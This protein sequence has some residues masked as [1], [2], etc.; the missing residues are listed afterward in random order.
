M[1]GTM[2]RRDVGVDE[3]DIRVVVVEAGTEG[4]VVV[5]AE[6]ISTRID[7]GVRRRLMRYL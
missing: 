3:M 5:V 1:I 6:V 2:T 4:M 7:L